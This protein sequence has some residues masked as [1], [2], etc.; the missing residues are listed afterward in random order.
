MLARIA[1]KAT[2]LLLVCGAVWMYVSG[3]PIQHP[4][5]VLCPKPPVQREIPVKGLGFAEGWHLSAVAEYKIRARVLGTKR[6][7]SGPAADLV[8][9]DVALGWGRMSD[10]AVLDRLD[11]SMSNRFFFYEWSEE[12]G[13]APE[14]AQRSAANNHVIAANDEVRKAVRSLR[15]GQI[16]T[17]EGYLVNALA[18]GGNGDW[19]SSLS[20][21]DTG[22]GACE[23]FYVERMKAVDSLADEI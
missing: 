14:E 18:P 13:I 12:P 16:V 2:A 6:Y 10:Q 5:G 4:P 19:N 11:L 15:P 1:T 22:N 20:R 21:T 17:M 8:P 7:H 3:R 23:V 9:V